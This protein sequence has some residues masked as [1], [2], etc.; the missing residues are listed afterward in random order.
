MFLGG[1]FVHCRINPLKVFVDSEFFVSYL[2]FAVEG[3]SIVFV[4]V[5]FSDFLRGI[6]FPY[7]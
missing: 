5:A 3:L 1:A 4:A 2:V 7:L 6:R